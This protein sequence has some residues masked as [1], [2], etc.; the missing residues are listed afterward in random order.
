MIA[1]TS[2]TSKSTTVVQTSFMPRSA[3]DQTRGDHAIVLGASMAGL[4]AARAL[5][6]HYALVTLLERDT[7]PNGDAGAS[8]KGVPQGRHPH[9]ILSR[10]RDILEEFFPGLTADLVERGAILGDL[11]RDAR[12]FLGG[13]YL[14]QQESG[15]LSLVASRPL[16]ENRV[17]AH[18]LALPNVR[19]IADR[20]IVGLEADAAGIRILGVRARHRGMGGA[21]DELLLADLVVDATGRGSQLPA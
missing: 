21:G 7:F 18:L 15:L 9:G 5:A 2:A 8:R 4:L 1:D 10:G 17:R 14:C 13:G 16:L 19:I 12:F 3:S 6:D 11:T 20:D